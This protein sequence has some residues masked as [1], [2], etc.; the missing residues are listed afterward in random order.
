MAKNTKLRI[1]ALKGFLT[2]HKLPKPKPPGR[3][4]EVYN[5]K[6]PASCLKF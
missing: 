6:I 5:V 3:P 4:N 2:E 1:E